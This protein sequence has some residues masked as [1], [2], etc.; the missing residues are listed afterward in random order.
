MNFNYLTEVAQSYIANI[1]NQRSLG[2]LDLVLESEQNGMAF[3][4]LCKETQKK[5]FGKLI[6]GSLIYITYDETI[7]NYIQVRREEFTLIK[8]LY[9]APNEAWIKDYINNM[10]IDAIIMNPPFDKGN[11]IW[12]ICREHINNPENL[13]CLMPLNQYRKDNS[14]QYIGSYLFV[15]EKLFAEADLTPNLMITT[16]QTDSNNTV[17]EDWESLG[18][19]PNFKEFYTWNKKTGIT[20]EFKHPSDRSKYQASKTDFVE[21]DRSSSKNK[22]GLH[23]KGGRGWKWNI[24]QDYNIDTLWP[25]SIAYIRFPSL[26]ARDNFSTYWYLGFTKGPKHKTLSALSIYGLNQIHLRGSSSI[27]IPQIDWE[28]ISGHPLWNEDLDS[29]VL[30]VMGLKWNENK[31]GVIKK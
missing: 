23:G 2:F 7:Y 21:H 8:E 12:N 19:D 31:D 18:R 15:N 24:D 9:L 22:G 17:W 28:K 4:K 26:K 30:D 1:Y 16:A 13:V 5:V 27:A 14:F 25:N 6:P 11:E 29:A 20:L 3:L 10:S